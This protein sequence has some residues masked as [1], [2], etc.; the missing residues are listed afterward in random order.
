MDEACKGMKE[1][2]EGRLNKR[3]A[4]DSAFERR[5]E[6]IFERESGDR[7]RQRSESPLSRHS[8]PSRQHLHHRP[9][10]FRRSPSRSPVLPPNTRSPE[11]RPRP[12]PCPVQSGS[13]GENSSG[14]N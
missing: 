14:L 4:P 13:M 10:L 8:P 9:S 7:K 3:P 5:R 2:F 6:N 1:S 12:L 11:T